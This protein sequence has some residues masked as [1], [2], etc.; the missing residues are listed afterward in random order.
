VGTAFGT[1]GLRNLRSQ[2]P[3]FQESIRGITTPAHRRLSAALTGTE[4]AIGREIADEATSIL[5]TVIETVTR[6]VIE[7]VIGTEVEIVTV[8]TEAGAIAPGSM[9]VGR[10]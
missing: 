7:I 8:E 2:V 4:T 9:I 5:A 6:T 10:D 3:L 1:R